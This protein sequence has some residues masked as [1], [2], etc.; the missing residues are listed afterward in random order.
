MKRQRLALQFCVS[1]GNVMH[2]R[3][4]VHLAPPEIHI[5]QHPSDSSLLDT[6]LEQ[7]G[8]MYLECI[9][10]TRRHTV[11]N[12]HSDAQLLSVPRAGSC[13]SGELHLTGAEPAPSCMSN[14]F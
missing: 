2:S 12:A 6:L 4:A 8:E 13:V 7:E 10:T 9:G 1:K 14:T 5:T 11:T 3:A